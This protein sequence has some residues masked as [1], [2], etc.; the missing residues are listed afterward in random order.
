ML[1]AVS[2]LFLSIL[3]LFRVSNGAESMPEMALE[4]R[5]DYVR[6]LPVKI[7]PA[8][9]IDSQYDV[10]ID[11]HHRLELF[12]AAGLSIV[13]A[14]SVNYEHP[15]TWMAPYEAFQRRSC[16]VQP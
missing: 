3:R 8:I 11:G 9:I 2:A 16:K 1:M 14:V 12:K 4:V 5:E 6:D 7:L 10:V 13:P 15:E